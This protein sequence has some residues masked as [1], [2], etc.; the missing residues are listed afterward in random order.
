MQVLSSVNLVS[1][2][3]KKGFIEVPNRLWIN[4][5]LLFFQNQVFRKLDPNKNGV[6][7]LNNMRKFYC[8][9]K[10]PKVVSGKKLVKLLL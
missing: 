5:L 8:T 7:S 3:L 2:L 9:K 1:I 6:I 10:H 4:W